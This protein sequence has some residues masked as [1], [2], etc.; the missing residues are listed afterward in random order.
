MAVRFS[1]LFSGRLLHPKRFMILIS[2]RGWVDARAIVQ[3][4]GLSQLNKA[5]YLIVSETRDL[6]ACSIVPQLTTLTRAPIN[7][8]WDFNLN[9]KYVESHLWYFNS[10]LP[11]E[12]FPVLK[13][14]GSRMYQWPATITRMDNCFPI[15]GIN[16]KRSPFRLIDG[17]LE[18]CHIS[19]FRQYLA[20]DIN[21]VPAQMK[22][23]LQLIYRSAD[24]RFGHLLVRKFL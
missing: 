13:L 1:A 19:Y 11:K 9:Q 8:Q 20:E 14:F 15:M 10:Y 23:S 6:P 16:K 18:I 2:V 5:N 21:P 7:S 3:L 22:P 24:V 17:Q 4:E 12:M